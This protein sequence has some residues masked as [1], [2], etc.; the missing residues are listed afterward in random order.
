MTLNFQGKTLEFH[1]E[2]ANL[3]Q[4]LLLSCLSGRPFILK[5][6]RGEDENPGLRSYEVNL[7]KLIEKM[8]N[9][10][11]ININKTGTKLIFKPGIIDCFEGL[12]IEHKCDLARSVTYYLEVACL[13]GI[14]GKTTLN[15]ELEGNTIDEIDQ[16]VDSFK[17]SL[18]HLLTQFG[19]DNSLKIQV[20]K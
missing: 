6:I 1:D 2:H 15:M 9:G 16:T 5:G 17:S 3:R 13:L 14:F 12:L 18:T 11:E 8:T 4:L 19:A 20:K 10:T 7:L